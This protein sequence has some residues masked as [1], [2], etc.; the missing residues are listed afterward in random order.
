MAELLRERNNH[1]RVVSPPTGHFCPAGL[2]KQANFA[3]DITPSLPRK[4]KIAIHHRQSSAGT[5]VAHLSSDPRL[6]RLRPWEAAAGGGSERTRTTR[7]LP[8]PSRTFH[9]TLHFP[10]PHHETAAA[11]AAALIFTRDRIQLATPTRASIESKRM[12]PRTGSAVR[13]ARTG[14][15]GRLGQCAARHGFKSN[16]QTRKTSRVGSISTQSFAV[17]GIGSG[18]STWVCQ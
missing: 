9:K 3:V 13:A 10:T 8:K 16:E 17:P 4:G 18:T 14:Q 15:K 11:L 6:S 2:R 1:T 5:A 7:N 12:N